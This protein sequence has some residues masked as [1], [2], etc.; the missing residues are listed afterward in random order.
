MDALMVKRKRRRLTTTL[1]VV[2]F[3]VAAV[4]WAYS[5]L[6]DSS[7]P[8][9]NLPLWTAF[10]VLCPPSLLSA[11][12]IDV[13]PASSGFT[14]MW[15]VIGLLNSALYAVVGMVVGKLRWKADNETALAGSGS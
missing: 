1:A 9:F 4:I 15:L 8:H 7:P 6:T 10:I 11:P 13:E 3:L 5:K 12:L 2:G 14:M